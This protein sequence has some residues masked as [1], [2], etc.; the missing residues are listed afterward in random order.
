M[1][2]AGIVR[3]I[4]SAIMEGHVAGAGL[5]ESVVRLAPRL[6]DATIELHRMVGPLP[7]CSN[8]W[9]CSLSNPTI[10]PPTTSLSPKR[11]RPPLK[12]MHNFLPS[13]VKFHYQFNL[14]EMSNIIGGLCR[15]TKDE[16]RDPLKVGQSTQSTAGA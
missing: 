9:L 3:S 14:R 2:G 10:P 4:Y 15:M 13:A 7:P 1:P 11:P 16:F 12:V 8:T 5:D 6:V